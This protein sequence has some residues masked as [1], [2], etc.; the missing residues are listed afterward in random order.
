MPDI[1][2]FKTQPANQNIAQPTRFE[3]IFS[4][5]PTTKFFCQTVVLP[6]LSAGFATQPTP[7]VDAKLSYDK[8]NYDTL[9]VSMLLD[10]DLKAFREVHLWMRGI[11]FPTSF[12]ERANLGNLSSVIRNAPKPEYADISIKVYNSNWQPI[13]LFKYYDAFPTMLGALNY[14]AAD[15]PENPMLVDVSFEYL[16]FDV[17]IF[18][19]NVAN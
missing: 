12:E 1:Q 3:M 4:R 2:T 17:E 18:P 11:G 13:V 7:F 14:S 10:E 19:S 6:G 16:Y 9:S 5:L 15:S 8:L